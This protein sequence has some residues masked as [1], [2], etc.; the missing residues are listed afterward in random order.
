MRMI[1]KTLFLFVISF[2]VSVF[3]QGQN[4][5]YNFLHTEST[6]ESL[7]VNTSNVTGSITGA[8]SVN[9][10][11]AGYKI[12]LS[13]PP[14]TNGVEP[15]LSVLYSSMGNSSPFG[16]GWSLG[17]LS[18]IGR[19]GRNQFHDDITSAV[20]FTVNDRFVL[21]GQRL[22]LI[23]GDYGINGSVYGFE[24]EGF[25]RITAYGGTAGDPSYFIMETKDGIK[26]E[27]GKEYNSRHQNIAG[28]AINWHLSKMIY[29]DG[30]YIS[31]KYITEHNWSGTLWYEHVIDEIHYTG[32]DLASITPFAK[33]K[34]TYLKRNEETVRYQGGSHDIKGLVTT[35][36]TISTENEVVKFYDFLYGYRNGNT[37]LNEIR[38]RSY[39]GTNL[40]N[41][42]FKYGDLPVGNSVTTAFRSIDSNDDYF[43][44]NLNGDGNTD[45]L[46]ARRSS[47]NPENHTYFHGMSN[48]PFNVTL[49][50]T[51]KIV[52]VA[53]FNGDN[54]DD[55]IDYYTISETS[56]SI[57]YSSYRIRVF[58]NNDPNGNLNYS[59]SYTLQP[60]SSNPLLREQLNN[61]HLA[62]MHTGDFNADG[63]A[64][65]LFINGERLFITYGQ[66][67][68]SQPLTDWQT[69][70]SNISSF[71][72][73]YNWGYDVKKIAIMDYNGDGKSDIFVINGGT[74]AVF[75]FE[76]AT[77]LKEIFYDNSTSLSLENRLFDQR[78][79]TFYG[80]FNAD[81]N[82]DVLVRKG[83]SN[84]D[85]WHIN[86]SKANGF[87][88][89]NFVWQGAPVITQTDFD[90]YVGE[91]V[92]VGDFNGDGRSD[93]MMIGE[94][95]PLNTFTD[96]YYSRGFSFDNAIYNLHNGVSFTYSTI[97]TPYFGNDG[98]ATTLYR[99]YTSQDPLD[100]FV[101]FKS[102]E[103]FLVKVRNGEDYTT[104][105][106]YKL[107][108][109]EIGSGDDFYIRGPLENVNGNSSNIELP[110]W[111]VKEFKTEDG[112]SFNSGDYNSI[113]MK[114]Q[115]YKYSN[116]KIHRTGKGLLGFGI[117]EIED[118]WSYL[119]NK[120]YNHVNDEFGL[121]IQDSMV[122]EFVTGA[123]FT[124]TETSYNIATLGASRYLM[125][126]SNAITHNYYENR[127]NDQ[128]FN[129][130]DIYANPTNITTNIYAGSPAQLIESQEVQSLY[131]AFG[132]TYPDKPTSVTTILFRSGEASYTSTS[133]LEYNSIGQVTARKLFYGQPKEL[134]YLYDY[135]NHGSLYRERK[136]STGLE[137]QIIH[138]YYDDY[139]RYVIEKKNIF[140]NTIYAATYDPKWGKPLTITDET[141]NTTTNT[142]D[143]WGRSLTTTSST[144]ILVTKQYQWM[145]EPGIKK[146]TTT[147]S[148]RPS[149][150]VY[151]DQFNRVV[152][153]ETQGFGGHWIT[154]NHQFDR[155][156]NPF[157]SE[158]PHKNGEPILKSINEYGSAY[159]AQRLVNTSSNISSFGD[160]EYEYN[161]A[162]GREI[163]TVNKPDGKTM[164]NEVDAAGKTIK[165]TES[166]GTILEY[167]YFSHGG[168]KEVMMGGSV[169]VSMEYDEYNRKKKQIDASA[170]ITMYDYDGFGRL[171][172]ETNAKG[173]VTTMQ[174]DRF[175]RITQ[176]SRNEGI[177]TYEYWPAGIA[178]KAYNLKKVIG[179][180]G[181]IQEIDYDAFGRIIS[182]KTTID[183]QSFETTTQYDALDRVQSRTLPSGLTLQYEYDAWSYLKRIYSGSTTYV[184]IDEVNGRGQVTKYTLGNGKQSIYEYFH[185]IP[186][187]YS[188]A[189]GTYEYNMQWNYKNGNLMKRW[190]QYGNKDTM[191][192]DI[193]D[194]LVRWTTQAADM[195]MRHDTMTYAD[196]GNILSKTDV[197]VYTYDPTRI[198]ATT[199][200]TNPKGLIKDAQQ[201]ITYN[202]FLQPDTIREGAYTLVYSYGYHGNR[203]KS[204]LT[205]N[206][207]VKE[208][209]Y[210]FGEY[211]KVIN[212]QGTAIVHYISLDGQLKVIIDSQG[213]TH[214][215]HYVYTDHLGSIIKVTDAAGYAEVSQTFDPWGR[216]RDFGVWTYKDDNAPLY[217]P[218]W[219]YRGY[220]G[221]EHLPE[222]RLINMN[223]RLYDPELARMLSPDNYVQDGSNTQNYNRYSY[224]YNNPL[225]YS[226]PDGQFVHLI[227]SAAISVFT[228]G[229][230][231][232]MQHKPFF[233][234]AL[235]EAFIGFASGVAAYGV[236]QI[237]GYVGNEFLRSGF[238]VLAHG[239]FGGVFSR[240]QGGSYSDGFLAGGISSAA[241]S[242]ANALKFGPSSVIIVGSISGGLSAAATG[243]N[244]W[245]GLRQGFIVSALN[246]ALHEDVVGNEGGDPR[247]EKAKIIFAEQYLS[248]EITQFEYIMALDVIDQ[249]WS[250]V[251][252]DI[253][254]K[255]MESILTLGGGAIGKLVQW[256]IAARGVSKVI[257]SFN[258][259]DDVIA[260]PS[261]LE[262]KSL[263][264]VQKILRNTPGWTEGVMNKTR[265]LDK[266]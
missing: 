106:D 196:N 219:L 208:T 79:L 165:T 250:G 43:A 141:L 40:N 168:T 74:S 157:E 160:V 189:D 60:S 206:G 101:G 241:S 69:V 183:G 42:S 16:F 236:G 180:A 253:F 83:N 174:Y 200:I 178:G 109:E 113:K 211:E 221:H 259:V 64:D 212:S 145:I 203:I 135:Y 143:A 153:T 11:A 65:L 256:G 66:R 50:T 207:V 46:F 223:G 23:S 27:Y 133:K 240:L 88:R 216:R 176:V 144:G 139:G 251:A 22:I 52:S 199:E 117:M 115:T 57:S 232:L 119:R 156:G 108:N 87:E 99:L 21:N 10:G 81:G 154:K 112:T 51:S 217:H 121:M 237:A 158:I 126:A 265:S 220:T 120:H 224:G 2:L 128:I 3:V 191:V 105:F 96:V 1:K 32:N 172:S 59:N 90:V 187:K 33:V 264:E 41:T 111:L 18:A 152:R 104:I 44:S 45:F 122:T 164:S 89:A 228:N 155:M 166:N 222:F 82:T 177:T 213:S 193:L 17:G 146:E 71:T 210:Y 34:F 61:N 39:D 181:D 72:S 260:N 130:Y 55:V 262:G 192:Y 243:G 202:S 147:S 186:V 136:N 205:Y 116:A 26:Y 215:P 48:I 162:Q 86:Y 194:R 49:H 266:G 76:T 248:G 201:H 31:Y 198:Y 118:Q 124:K 123:D 231:N 229:V 36:I 125:T 195:S 80:D 246:H 114:T 13:M 163:V 185:G 28:K 254:N 129:T 77:N 38:E 85:Q 63:L 239:H 138:Y 73:I 95:N 4:V 245:Q 14:G 214:T 75:E 70:T 29:P 197:G 170:G 58:F 230:R 182:E 261:L 167:T 37:F 137:N 103:N 47:S 249:D 257:S 169:L 100:V 24:S 20:D 67:N 7:N 107:M 62:P 25:E 142:Y 188:T 244:F 149:S 127:R 94:V 5:T 161:Y 8:A 159:T 184:N 235:K 179:H 98:K 12:D 134:V 91:T 97:A 234:G 68:L 19:T 238:Q 150:V 227:I 56:G 209:K 190:D 84:S 92:S 225:K 226:D 53:D 252:A 151:F 9:N 30:N 93:V 242:I 218:I 255:H 175:D 6:I 204:A 140:G 148:N 110:I 173:Q 132:S 102:K 247:I 15:E 263:S 171:I 233:Q 35:N 131:E 258:S 78:F 54:L